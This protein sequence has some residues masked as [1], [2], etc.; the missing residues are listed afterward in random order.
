MPPA[1]TVLASVP[2]SF[3]RLRGLQGRIG[4]ASGTLIIAMALGLAIVFA[5]YA[6]SSLLALAAVNVETLAQQMAREL[7]SGMDRF[8]REIQLQAQNSVL[9]DPATSAPR[10]RRILEDIQRIYPEFAHISLVDAASGKVLAATGGVF[11]GGDGAGRPVFEEGRKGLFVGDVHEAVRLAAL[12]PRPSGGEPLRFLDVAAPVVDADGKLLRVLASHLSWQWTRAIKERILRPVEASRKVQILLVDTAGSVVLAPDGSVPVGTGLGSML[13]LGSKGLP[14]RWSDGE[15]YLT[16]IAPTFATGAFKGL[17][18][19]VVVRQPMSVVLAP[20]NRLGALFILGSLFLGAVAAAIA[21]VVAGRIAQPLTDLARAAEA[22]PTGENLSS[23]SHFPEDDLAEVATV[24]HAFRRVTGE[25]L[26]RAERLLG[27]LDSIYRTAP[28]GMC[29]VDADSRYLRLNKV[30]ADAFGLDVERSVGSKLIPPS[31]DADFAA[32]ITRMHGSSAAPAE[33][34]EVESDGVDG[35]RAWQ[36]GIAP[37][38]DGAGGVIGASIVVTDITELKRAERALRRADER[39]DK[40]VAMLAHELRNPL[41]PISNALHILER[42]PPE[43]QAKRMLEMSKTHVK[44]MVRLI[45]DLLDVSRVGRNK[46]SMMLENVSARQVCEAAIETARPLMDA[47]RQRLEVSIEEGL[48]NMRADKVRMAQM[49]GNLLNNASKYTQEGGRV[50]LVAAVR[51]E[52]IRISVEDDGR[53]MPPTLIPHVFELFTQGDASLDRSEGGL[54]IGLSI[55]KS[56]AEMHGGG[57]SASSEG[58]GKGSCFVVTI[59]IAPATEGA[60]ADSAS[61]VAS[62]GSA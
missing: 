60:P 24:R 22:L 6:R 42:G 20:A 25:A 54:G 59:P 16:S 1:Q 37:L 28:V 4:L 44:H 39:K 11:E 51:G 31:R 21:W 30:W 50:S 36:T 23:A 52:C 62:V 12:L 32:A 17:G 46:V 38:G 13:D 2:K 47:K 33:F 48:P 49:L 18:W 27:Q 5:A 26:E 43:P 7:S 45:D 55:V 56:V 8:A 10:A 3:T 35:P 34:L 19:K 61:S 29:L 14:A 15:E 57:V 41:A 9:S 53:G 58:V 40:F